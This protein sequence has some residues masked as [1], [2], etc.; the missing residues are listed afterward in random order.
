M[1]K[2]GRSRNR[3]IRKP[4][5]EAEIAKSGNTGNQF[6]PAALQGGLPF[7]CSCRAGSPCAV[8][9]PKSGSNS[10]CRKD[11]ADRRSSMLWF[12]GRDKGSRW[13]AETQHQHAVRA[14]SGPL[15]ASERLDW[16][17]GAVP[18]AS[19]AQVQQSSESAEQGAGLCARV[20]LRGQEVHARCLF[21]PGSAG[22]RDAGHCAGGQPIVALAFLP[23]FQQ[24]PLKRLPG[25]VR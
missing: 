15:E 3:E 1:R 21:A 8:M 14:G 18:A 13:L 7:A 2:S 9:L 25:S 16:F 23:G 10:A 22:A 5:C 17:I 6:R 24:S 11:N 20:T 19:A 4:A 12:D